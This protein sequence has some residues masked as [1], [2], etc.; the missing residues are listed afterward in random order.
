MSS[1]DLADSVSL[2]RAAVLT[3]QAGVHRLS[4]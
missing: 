2:A 3:G 4:I 1:A